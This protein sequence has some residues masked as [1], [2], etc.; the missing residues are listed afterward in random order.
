MAVIKSNLKVTFE[1]D[2][3]SLNSAQYRLVRYK[4][5]QDN[6]CRGVLTATGAKTIGVVY[7]IPEAA[8]GAA[9][10][11]ITDG[12][13][14]IKTNDQFS[15]GDRFIAG[16]DGLALNFDAGS[17]TTGEYIAGEAAEGAATGAVMSCKVYSIEIPLSWV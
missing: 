2:N 13:A 4:S 14:K 17:G 9:V 3:D 15:A 12:F 7:N 10:S 6:V 8:T 5:N 11:I 16:S 1:A